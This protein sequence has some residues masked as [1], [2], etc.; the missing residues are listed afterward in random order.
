MIIKLDTSVRGRWFTWNFA[1]ILNLTIRRNGIC[2]TRNPSWRM[3]LK[4]ISGILRYKRINESRPGNQTYRYLKKTNLPNSDLCRLGWSMAKTEEK[5]KRE[6]STLILLE[7][8]KK[9]WNMKVTVIPVVIGALIT[10]TRG[11]ILEDWE[12]WWQVE[13]I[14][15]TRPEYLEEGEIRWWVEVIQS[16]RPEYLEEWKIKMTSGGYS[17]CKARILGGGRNMMMS[18]G[19]SNYKAR[20]LGGLGNK[21]TSRGY[22]NYKVRILGGLGNMMTSGGYSNYKA[23]I[24]GGLGNKMM[25]RGYSKYMARILGDLKRLAVT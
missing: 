4:N 8:W 16:T 18:G 5:A 9:L 23:R 1:R 7:N 10:V 17:N 13:A 21:M 3:K 11:L 15:T 6:I 19:Y 12:I 22:S 25:S 24:L 2:T 20:I 14:Q